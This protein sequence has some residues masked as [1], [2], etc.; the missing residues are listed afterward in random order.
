VN[1]IFLI[2]KI[3]S[4]EWY[5]RKILK[6]FQ[7][8]LL[9]KPIDWVIFLQFALLG[10]TK[11]PAWTHFQMYGI[12]FF[13][14]PATFLENGVSKKFWKKIQLFLSVIP[15]IWAIIRGNLL[16]GTLRIAYCT[17]SKVIK[18][19]LFHF[20]PAVGT[21]YER[22]ILEKIPDVPLDSIFRWCEFQIFHPKHHTWKNDNQIA[23]NGNFEPPISR[24]PALISTIRQRSVSL[25][26]HI[27]QN[28]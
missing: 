1:C 15:I 23:K 14:P 9:V 17:T 26:V 27:Y 21:G 22:N 6:N 13:S 18:S 7:T 2:S 19:P 5:V 16:L 25:W 4:G 12:A 20:K 28:I 3:I 11:S 8:Y 10:V 24:Q